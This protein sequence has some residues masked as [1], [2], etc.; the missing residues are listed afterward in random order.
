MCSRH[1]ALWE[2][3]AGPFKGLTKMQRFALM[4][5]WIEEVHQA[6]LRETGREI[7]DEI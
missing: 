1:H 3:H 5:G 4:T 2:Q 7:G 6:Y